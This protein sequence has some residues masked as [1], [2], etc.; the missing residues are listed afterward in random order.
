MLSSY[1]ITALEYKVFKTKSGDP[2]S[3]SS[4]SP[5]GGPH[6]GLDGGTGEKEGRTWLTDRAS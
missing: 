5:G 6:C 1:E 4:L 3:I 2:S